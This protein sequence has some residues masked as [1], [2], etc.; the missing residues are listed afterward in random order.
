MRKKKIK[1][2]IISEIKN[3]FLIILGTLISAVAFV[4]FLAPN[5]ITA[6]G[7]SGIAIT[8]YH[9]FD[10]QMGWIILVL[11]IPLFIIG[12]K[13][14]G[15]MYGIRTLIGIVLVSLFVDLLDGKYFS[16][17]R[18]ETP[19]IDMIIS[20]IFGGV[21]LGIGIGIVFRA[22]GSGGGTDIIA[23]VLGKHT[24]FTPGTVFMIVDFFI[25][26]ISGILLG[27]QNTSINH[28]NYWELIFYGLISLYISSRVV[29]T[30]L[31]GF[32]TSKSVQIISDRKNEIIDYIHK[33]M[34]R[35]AT[36]LKAIGTYSKKEKD[37]IFC[38][39]TRK[40]T[41]ELKEFITKIDKNAFMIIS[42]THQVLGY[43]FSPHGSHSI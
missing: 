12:I 3:I 5:K 39:I 24:S 13:F 27:M 23:Q 25:I 6:G 8:V 17:I 18:L 32:S 28:V 31:Q 9:L 21:L 4:G 15:R 1:K 36:L 16:F 41:T 42:D 29:D 35:G 26:A 34:D 30:V 20:A 2:F 33:K 19:E 38:V 37:V 11:N 22:K 10:I 7:V 43:G 40:E 14:L